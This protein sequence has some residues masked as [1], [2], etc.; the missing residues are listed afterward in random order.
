MGTP[1]CGAALAV[2]A[3]TC[4]AMATV[5]GS[6]QSMLKVLEPDSEVL[7]RIQKEF[8]T[9]LRSGEDIK[10]TCFYEDHEIKPVGLVK[11]RDIQFVRS[12]IQ[13]TRLC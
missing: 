11:Q 9:M 13:L 6:N 1:H 10:I 7:A 3:S 5:F 12:N 2:W 8:H 4:T